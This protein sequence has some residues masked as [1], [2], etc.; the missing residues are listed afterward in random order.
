MRTLA[1]SGRTLLY[2]KSTSNYKGSVL[3]VASLGDER[4]VNLGQR[5]TIPGNYRLDGLSLL[6]LA[7]D[8]RVGNGRI[9]V[10]PY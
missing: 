1:E 9:R 6:V 5:H 2:V 10:L 4:A 3:L 8:V 7:N